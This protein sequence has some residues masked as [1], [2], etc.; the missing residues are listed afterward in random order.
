[1]GYRSTLITDQWDFKFP[2]WFAE[3]YKDRY[4]FG[5]NNS[6]PLSSKTEVSRFIDDIEDDIVRCLQ[7][8]NSNWR[9]CAVWLYED[10][11]IARIVFDKKGAHEFEKSKWCD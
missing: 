4:N 7:E 6:L 9:I 10:G 2:D 1:M 8:Q 11:K 5:E 3:K